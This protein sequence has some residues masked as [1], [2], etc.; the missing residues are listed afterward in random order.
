MSGLLHRHYAKNGNRQDSEEASGRYD[1]GERGESQTIDQSLEPYQ[2]NNM[3]GIGRS[4]LGL[5]EM[6]S[7]VLARSNCT[8]SRV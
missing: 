3:I 5:M 7:I 4:R 6:F 2:C 1:V 8:G